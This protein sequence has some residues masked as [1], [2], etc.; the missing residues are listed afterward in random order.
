VF[1][2]FIH[3]IQD[4][5]SDDCEARNA[6]QYSNFSSFFLGSAQSQSPKARNGEKGWFSHTPHSKSRCSQ[7]HKDVLSLE[8]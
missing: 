2:R 7:K 4:F 8:V 6:T 1:E 3:F 5:C